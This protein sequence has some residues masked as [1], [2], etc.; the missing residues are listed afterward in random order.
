MSLLNAISQPEI[1]EAYY[2]YK[3]SLCCGAAE[4]KRLRAYIDAGAYLPVW[5]AI[6][7]GEAM[8]LPRRAV[9]SKLHAEKKRVVYIYPEPENTVFKLLT[10]LLLRSC[11]EG[12]A[13]GLWSFRPGRTAK[14]A[15][16]ALRSVPGLEGMYAYKLDISNYFNSVP[17]ERF[18]PL[19]E[20]T[21]APDPAL[22]AFLAGL[23]REPAVLEKGEP[24]LEQKGIMA[25]TPQ[26]AFYANLYLA[27]L[28]AEFHRRGVIYARYSDDIIL[29][30]S[31]EEELE[32]HA[33][34]LRAALAE[35]GLQINPKKEAR[36]SPE[37]GWTFLGFFCKGD[38]VDIAPAT[39]DKLKAKM[40]RKT[41]AL[42]RWRDRSGRS[43]V[44]A[45]AAFIRVFNRKLLESPE[46]RELSWSCWF[47]SV[48]NTADSLGVI[49]RYAQDCLRVLI[50]G[51]R[52]KGRY[53]VRYGE[54]KNLGYR[55]LVHEYYAHQKAE[56]ERAAGT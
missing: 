41:R 44:Q 27:E 40:R 48:I 22:Y 9:I 6:R 17:P 53:R 33:A 13:P 3:C 4:A 29:F 42:A 23:L 16:R 36:F 50:S 2:A 10:W 39:L 11:D 38:R 1:W 35:K 52:T 14:D 47:F 19:L 7:R 26:S 5:E 34:R 28:D 30:A 18:L 20:Q 25:G 8:P 21:L 31:D 51:T 55:S 49:D 37:S 43:G 24:L 54:L 46:D 56:A 12:F 32:A 15:I 45:A